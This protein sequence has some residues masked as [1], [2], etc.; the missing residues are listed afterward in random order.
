[1]NQSIR[2]GVLSTAK[3]AVQKVIP[4]IQKSTLGTVSAIASRNQETAQAVAR[5][6]SI[7]KAYGSY[8]EILSDPDIDAVYIPLPNHMHI[9]WT[10]AA[11]AAGKHVL[12]EKPIGLSKE[13]TGKLIDFAKAYP[14]IKVMEAFMYRFHPQWQ[15]TKELIGAGRIGT[16]KTVH[17]FFSYYN[18]DPKNIRNQAEIGGGGL[19]DIGCYCI[20]FPRFIFNEEPE[21]VVSLMDFDPVMQTDRLSSGM[22]RF[23]GGKSAS[24]TCSTQ[25][26][27]Y[28][29]LHI[30]GDKGQLVVEIPVNAP[31]QQN[32]KITV[33]TADGNEEIYFPAVDQYSLQA[34]AFAQAILTD[35]PVP[36]QLSDALGNM[37]V[38]DALKESSKLKQWVIID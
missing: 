38:I 17:A 16:V 22:L 25:L 19:M 8:E 21:A 36:T 18:I 26:F 6:L 23:S 5:E 10:M 3:I 13:E 24:F 31:P 30:Y 14:Q 33:S 34:D 32:C 27:P 15:R 35:S 2:W 12:C 4:A 37:A 1:M 7:P 20:S 9:E 11:I 28:Q 29:R